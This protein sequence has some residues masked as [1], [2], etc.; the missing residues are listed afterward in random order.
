[1]HKCTHTHTHINYS[2]YSTLTFRLSK[3]SKTFITGKVVTDPGSCT[4][5]PIQI[6]NRPDEECR[7]SLWGNKEQCPSLG[8]GAK[9]GVGRGE[10]GPLNGVKV[11]AD[12]WVGLER[13]LRWSA[14]PFGGTLCEDPEEQ[15]PTFTPQISEAPVGFLV[16]L[17]CIVHI[18]ASTV[19]AVIF[20]PS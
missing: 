3:I 2:Y 20:S 12:P 5:Q 7:Q 6:E 10:P 16:F 14:H 18:F 13:W 11:A 1:M 19:H 9:A 8:P 4:L 15:N 17:Y